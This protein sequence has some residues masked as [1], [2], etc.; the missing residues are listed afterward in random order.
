MPERCAVGDGVVDGATDENSVSEFRDLNSGQR[1][2][3]AGVTEKAI[4]GKELFEASVDVGG[5]EGIT[6]EEVLS[7]GMDEFDASIVTDD[8][9]VAFGIRF[10]TTSEGREISESGG[11]RL[12]EERDEGVNGKRERRA[13]EQHALLDVLA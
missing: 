7:S 2:E 5:R 12:F 1:L 9:D 13:S 10:E 8:V 4:V 3:V 11:E 6:N